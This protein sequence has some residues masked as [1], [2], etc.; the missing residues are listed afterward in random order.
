LFALGIREVG[1]TTA[2]RLAQHFSSL[3]NLM[4]SDEQTLELIDDIGP[5]VARHIVVFFQQS[6]NNEVIEQLLKAGIDWDDVSVS[7]EPQTLPLRDQ[8]F[9]LTGTLQQFTR[10]LAKSKLEALGATV[11]GS[12]STKT[13]YL[14]AGSNP[15][16]KLD[17]AK[18]LGVQILTEQE[19]F[20]ML[21]I[22]SEA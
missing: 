6:H 22:G 4:E 11:A 14:V 19:L 17:K 13:N 7:T 16:S 2:K 5:V 21:T 9:V 20:D 15:G 8:R 1:E 10:E 12:V 18:Q 3:Q